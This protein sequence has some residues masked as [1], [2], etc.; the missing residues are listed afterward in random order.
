MPHQPILEC[1]CGKVY[2]Y[3]AQIVQEGGD[4][5]AHRGELIF[6]CNCGAAWTEEYLLRDRDHGTLDILPPSPVAGEKR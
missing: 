1:T 3:T 2:D 4:V 6:T 5:R